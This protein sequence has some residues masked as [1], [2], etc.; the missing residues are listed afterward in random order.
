MHSQDVGVIGGEDDGSKGEMHV[1]TNALSTQRDGMRVVKPLT[2]G[3]ISDWDAAE[4]LLSHSYKTCLACDPADHPL[5]LSEPSFNPPAAREKLAELVFEKFQ[6]PALF[7]GKQAV[8]SAFAAGRGTALVLE[9]GGGVT[10]ATAV[11]DGYALSKPLKRSALGGD[12]LNEMAL[13]SLQL[14]EPAPAVQPLYTLKRTAVGPGE[15]S[16]SVRD[17]PGT[18]PSY[19]RYAQLQLMKDVKECVC[20]CSF[21]A[22][23]P[24]GEMDSSAWEFEMPDRSVVDFGWERLHLPELL[25]TPNLLQTQPPPWTR[26]AGTDGLTPAAQELAGMVPEGLMGLP[27]MVSECIRMCDTDIR[28]ELWGNVV[29]SGGGSLLPGLPE[30]LH[31]RLNEI[32]PQMSMKVKVVAA[33]TPSERRWATW[34]GGSILASLGSFQQLWMSK[35]E[36]EE[37]GASAIHRKCP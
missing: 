14:R 11:H 10:T 12:L 27:E 3:V 7:L 34:I 5:M 1:G 28:R 4:A 2:D 31:A 25:F 19:H 24:G 30:R 37:N 22:P 35:Q 17:F 20:R 15:E 8:L 26:V 36:Y 16:V 6:A 33:S 32:V 21:S 18:H 23:P 29:L 9:I 13:K